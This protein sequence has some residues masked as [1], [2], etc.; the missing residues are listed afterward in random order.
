RNLEAIGADAAAHAVIEADA[1]PWLK[2]TARG[3]DRFDL[4][5]LDPPSFATTKSSRFSAESD[6]REIAA[7]AFQVLAPSGK[8][9]ACT[10]HRG[11]VRAKLRRYLHEAARD[12]GREV[13]QMKDMPD[14]TD[15]S[16]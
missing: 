14:P 16:P 12:A 11:I 3:T 2:E 10:N 5:I 9:L 4:A 15:S 7:L 6:F 13:L 1:I 8:L